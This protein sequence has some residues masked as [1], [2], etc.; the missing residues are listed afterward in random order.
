MDLPR[1]KEENRIQRPQL[2]RSKSTIRRDL[3]TIEYCY[4]IKSWERVDSKFSRLF[5]ELITVWN[6]KRPQLFAKEQVQNG[7]VRKFHTEKLMVHI[8]L[9]VN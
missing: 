3:P 8:N 1:Q 6:F 2:W 7:K 9:T 5:N 4:T